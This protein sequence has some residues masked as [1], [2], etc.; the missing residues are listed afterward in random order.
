MNYQAYSAT[1]TYYN[2]QGLIFC[3]NYTNNDDTYFFINRENTIEKRVTLNGVP[4]DLYISTDNDIPSS[5][6]WKV[7]NTIFGVD[8]FLG[9]NDLIKA[10]ESVQEVK[11]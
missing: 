10:A 11:K 8:G 4:A 2:E 6:I 7:G 1:L 9:E 3:L 5:I